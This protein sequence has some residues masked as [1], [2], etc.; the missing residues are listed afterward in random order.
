MQ[1][2]FTLSVEQWKADYTVEK[3]PLIARP[4]H[5][6]SRAVGLDGP[7]MGG[8]ADSLTLC[9]AFHRLVLCIASSQPC[10]YPSSSRPPGLSLPP[11]GPWLFYRREMLLT[12]SL[13]P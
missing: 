2:A 7:S 5:E 9:V 10:R 13:A 3:Q 12:R 1:R 6:G 8:R 4:A 11:Q